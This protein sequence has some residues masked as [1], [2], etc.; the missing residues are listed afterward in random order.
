MGGA[1]GRA[2]G[3]D[4]YIQFN[5]CQ[6]Q[7]VHAFLSLQCARLIRMA[8]YSLLKWETTSHLMT[9]VWIGEL[10][11]VTLQYTGLQLPTVS[12][13]S[14]VTAVCVRGEIMFSVRLKEWYVASKSCGATSCAHA[15]N[16]MLVN[17]YLC[18]V[19]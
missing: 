8:R 12:V 4:S 18:A 1:G 7:S 19:V 10:H 17:V 11:C 3:R 9:P 2:D 6:Y 15:Q 16:G 5:C 13:R 14:A